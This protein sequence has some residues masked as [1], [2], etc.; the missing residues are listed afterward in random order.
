[1]AFWLAILAGALF[2]WVATRF[3]F[4][5]TWAVMFNIVVSVYA[6]VFLAPVITD[7]V[8]AAGETAWGT[9]L[10]LAAI[11][12]GAFLILHGT[13]YAFIT[14]Q[15]NV[16]FPKIFDTV[17]AGV[18]GFLAGFLV[19]SFTALLICVTPI[20]RDNLINKAGLGR[21]S[22]QANIA[23]IC[24][25]CDLVNT[26]VSDRD[27]KVTSKQAVDEL[28]SAAQPKPKPETGERAEPN[29]P[30]ALSDMEAGIDMG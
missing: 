15:A 5:E 18:L 29:E 14:G 8:P 24:W 27:D 11:A 23:Y 12:I 4:F 26:V 22:Q 6:A 19:L 9:A 13:T 17:L 28:L 16:S 25:W 7:A 3:G 2:A 20:S 1:M 21:Q 30:T 10:T